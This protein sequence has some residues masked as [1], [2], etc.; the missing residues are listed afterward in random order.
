MCCDKHR[1]YT[2]DRS[3]ETTSALLSYGE[4]RT[5]SHRCDTL[6]VTDSQSGTFSCAFHNHYEI[7]TVSHST[8]SFWSEGQV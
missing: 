7:E 3:Y 2:D 1:I 5:A 4:L 8:R 6:A